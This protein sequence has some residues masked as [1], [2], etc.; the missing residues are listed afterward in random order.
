MKNRLAPCVDCGAFVSPTALSCPHC[1]SCYPHGVEC[2]LC[3][4]RLRYAGAVS[5]WYK[6]PGTREGGWGGEPIYFHRACIEQHFVPRRPIRC[7]DCKGE[8][9]PPTIFDPSDGSFN[10]GWTDCPLCGSRDPYK[11][12]DGPNCEYCN[13]PI[14]GS[15]QDWYWIDRDDN[16]RAH[17]CCG[18]ALSYRHPGILDRIWRKLTE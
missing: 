5:R 11:I 1:K 8:L 7:S 18:N 12:G 13:L 17:R 2:R 10:P 6:L 14:Y 16:C 15:F 9:P 4:R 3:G